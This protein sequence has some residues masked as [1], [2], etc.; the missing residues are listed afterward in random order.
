MNRRTLIATL[1]ASTLALPAQAAQLSLNEISRYLNS[2]T[3]ATGEFTQINPDG[4]IST[5]QIYIKRPGRIRFE[6]NAPDNTLVMAGGGSVAVFDPKSNT[7]PERYPL[8]QTPLKIIL[9]RNVNLGQAN[10][11][12][13][14]S[15]DGTRTTVTAQD[16][17]HPE[18]GNIQ[19]VYTAKPTELRQWI[20]TDDSGQQTTVILG[21]L[22]KGGRIDDIKFN[23]VAETRRRGLDQ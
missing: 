17:Q 1:L 12:T 14:H 16:P 10:M 23:I 9:E 8:N 3:T 22:A 20:V 21:D 5:G 18:Y 13:G 11:V 19:M 4:T 7:G 2:F 15:S 6:Y